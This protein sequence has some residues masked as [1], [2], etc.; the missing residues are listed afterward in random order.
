ME[1]TKKVLLLQGN[2]V[3]QVVRD[4]LTDLHKLKKGESMKYSRKND[5]HPFE[6]GKE[7]TLQFFCE[8]GDCALFCLANHSKKRPNNLVVGRMFDFNLLDMI[9][10]GVKDF[11][12]ITSFPGASSLRPDAKVWCAPY[13]QGQMK[14]RKI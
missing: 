13:G 3:S 10:L 8:R 7:V 6:A 4:V 1:D 5:L 12:P 11:A 14:S 2:K 9:E